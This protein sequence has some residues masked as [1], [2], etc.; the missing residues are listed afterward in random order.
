VGLL[1]R[2]QTA[3]R[4]GISREGGPGMLVPVG[5]RNG[6]EDEHVEVVEGHLRGLS[7]KVLIQLIEAKLLRVKFRWLSLVD[8]QLFGEGLRLRSQD[9]LDL[10]SAHCPG[11]DQEDVEEADEDLK[12]SEIGSH[13]DPLLLAPSME[14]LVPKDSLEHHYKQ[15]LLLV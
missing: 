15:R 4:E 6:R 5:L 8:A 1:A 9:F 11:K 3:N 14:F 13:I 7:N 2:D 12:L 10:F